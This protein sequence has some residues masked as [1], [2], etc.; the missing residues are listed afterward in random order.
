VK[1][2]D[3]YQDKLDGALT[4]IILAC[5]SLHMPPEPCQPEEEGDV[6]LSDTD[7]NVKHALD[8]LHAAYALILKFKG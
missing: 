7:R 5:S 4:E 8:H 3:D 6:Y 1:P 2:R